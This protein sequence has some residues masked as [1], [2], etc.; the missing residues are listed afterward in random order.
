MLKYWGGVTAGSASSIFPQHP[1][2]QDIAFLIFII[3]KITITLYD[4]FQEREIDDGRNPHGLC[5]RNEPAARRASRKPQCA[6]IRPLYGQSQGRAPQKKAAF[7]AVAGGVGIYALR[8]PGPRCRRGGSPYLHASP[9]LGKNFQK[10]KNNSCRDRAPGPR[11][12][13]WGRR[14]EAQKKKE[15]V[16]GPFV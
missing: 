1:R 7:E 13:S 14:G 15:P 10:S 12:S 3:A 2:E 11:V 5:A 8:H 16:G 4:G 6:E 9:I